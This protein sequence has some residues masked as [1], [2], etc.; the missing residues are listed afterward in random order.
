V[1]FGL[2]NDEGEEVCMFASS[3]SSIAKFEKKIQIFN[4]SGSFKGVIEHMKFHTKIN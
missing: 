1:N 2:A 4:F 3:V